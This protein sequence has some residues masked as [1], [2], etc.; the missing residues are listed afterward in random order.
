MAN[1]TLK[2]SASTS[3]NFL[4]YIQNL[5][6]SQRESGKSRFPSYRVPFSIFH[7]NFEENFQLLWETIFAK[8][9]EKPERDQDIFHKEKEQFVTKL[10][11]EQA[12]S[13]VKF[14]DIHRTFQNWWGSFAGNFAIER[15]AD[16]KMSQLYYDLTN[17]QQ[18][19]EGELAVSILYDD[20]AFSVPKTMQNGLIV[21]IPEMYVRYSEVIER[22]GIYQTACSSSI[23]EEWN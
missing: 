12:A 2:T 18:R 22:L 4:I 10:F 8:I 19:T 21:S 3:L 11:N 16:D 6:L 13:L 7:E 5:Y 15:A 9:E 23:E 20:C 14:E 17:T 1:F